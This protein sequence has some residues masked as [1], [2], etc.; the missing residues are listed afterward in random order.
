M[1]KLAN[2]VYFD[3]TARGKDYDT[4]LHWR[5][6][7]ERFED[8]CG[9]KK[10]YDRQDI[11]KYVSWCRDSGFSLNSINVMIRPI[12]LLSELQV[13]SNGDRYW[14]FPKLDMKL[15]RDEDVSRP[16][17]KEDEI[18]K[19][20]KTAKDKLDKREIAVLVLST[21]YG[22]RRSEMALDSG[23][24][25]RKAVNSVEFGGKLY[26]YSRELVVRT[27]KGGTTT[28]HVVP[29][30]IVQYIDGFIPYARARVLSRFRK[31]N[32]YGW[33][34][35]RRSLATE[36]LLADV[37]FL[38][39]V[40]FMRWSD[41]SAMGG[42]GMLSIYAKRDQAKIDTIVFSKHPYLKYW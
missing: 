13:K 22:V 39:I 42:F 25:I 31:K 7:T 11:L 3:L 32:D 18:V 26:K 38:N 6:W 36:L 33:H 4:A 24:K 28:V 16:V 30:E 10:I 12:K 14:H 34:S 29:D 5:K 20:I 27:L 9:V 8:V 40:R 41:K 21:I 17:F 15:Q 19:L 2:L 37:S 35:V 1:G 23:L